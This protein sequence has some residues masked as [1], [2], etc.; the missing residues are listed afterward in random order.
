MGT[1]RQWLLTTFGAIALALVAST[2]LWPGAVGRMAR[3][4][5]HTS[6]AAAEVREEI[7]EIR[8]RLLAHDAV[9]ADWSL[10]PQGPRPTMDRLLDES[11]AMLDDYR[12]GLAREKVAMAEVALDAMHAHAQAQV[13]SAVGSE[14]AAAE[15][16]RQWLE[17]LAREAE[18][19]IESA[20][21]ACGRARAAVVQVG[22]GAA[23]DPGFVDDLALAIDAHDGLLCRHSRLLERLRPDGM[24]EFHDLL[25]AGDEARAAADFARARER[26]RK[27]TAAATHAVPASVPPPP[28][29]AAPRRFVGP[30]RTEFPT[31][32]TALRRPPRHLVVVVAPGRYEERVVISTGV[33]ITAAATDAAAGEARPRLTWRDDAVVKVTSR[34]PVTLRGLEIEGVDED[35]QKDAWAP[36]VHVTRGACRLEACVLSS[37]TSCAVADGS[38]TELTMERCEVR[39]AGETGVFALRSGTA[40]VID[41][42]IHDCVF[43]GVLARGAHAVVQD[44]RFRD[45]G[46]R[47]LLAEADGTIVAGSV[48]AVGCDAGALARTNGRA[49]LRDCRFEGG[50]R[51]V[52]AI[53]GATLAATATTVQGCSSE[54]AHARKGGKLLLT[55][56][57]FED[58][59]EWNVTANHTAEVELAGCTIRGGGDFAS[60]WVG[61]ASVARLV[62][63][64]LIGSGDDGVTV[65]GEG[66]SAHLADTRIEAPA[67]GGIWATKG[68]RVELTAC[69]ILDVAGVGIRVTEGA[70]VTARDCQILRGK[71]GGVLLSDAGESTFTGCTIRHQ[72]LVNLWVAGDSDPVFE[73]CTLFD[74]GQTGLSVRDRARGAYRGIDVSRATYSCI[75]IRDAANP[76]IERSRVHHAKQH[77]VYLH[78][79]ATGLLLD[80]VIESNDWNGVSAT[81]ASRPSLSRC[82]IVRN[83]RYG[84]GAFGASVVTLKATERLEGNGKADRHADEDSQIVEE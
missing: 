63:C 44:T 66:S 70:G 47:A 40:T 60:V 16:S 13:E 67:D 5:L 65:T 50:A 53:D 7:A 74:A 52:G 56:C 82:T 69:S 72:E 21:E 34:E 76:R 77:G 6:A 4:A 78:S 8:A 36:A 25:A 24:A 49:T 48:T 15:R 42:D 35:P 45:I 75:E 2:P 29:H 31:I 43:E 23:A 37:A 12:V 84:V 14:R 68:A 9:A 41:C 73:D 22:S 17:E 18:A 28:S 46:Q 80:C 10:P 58:A 11:E 32:A 81:E 71:S 83:G 27:A 20:A 54:T 59:A 79:G 30:A 39:R 64:T 19:E 33:T 26:Y 1:R 61:G 51:G 38:E 62:E 55:S 57:T 3:R